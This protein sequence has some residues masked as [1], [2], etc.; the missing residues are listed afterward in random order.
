MTPFVRST[1]LN[2]LD[3]FRETKLF[4]WCFQL[5]AHVITPSLVYN[6]S[7]LQKKLGTRSFPITVP[8]LFASHSQLRRSCQ[9]IIELLDPGLRLYTIYTI[10][11]LYWSFINGGNTILKQNKI[12]KTSKRFSFKRLRRS[13]FILDFLPKLDPLAM[14]KSALKLKFISQNAAKWNIACQQN[15]WSTNAKTN[16][17]SANIILESYGGNAP[18]SPSSESRPPAPP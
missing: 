14:R 9:L 8:K 16:W 4:D 6:L 12:C 18:S 15:W 17:C 7:C 10:A 13:W 1:K 3:L 2:A 5:K 11:I